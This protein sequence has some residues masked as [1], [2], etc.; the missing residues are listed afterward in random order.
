MKKLLLSLF[1]ATVAMSAMAFNYE[2]K[3]AKRLQRSVAYPSIEATVEKPV[4]LSRGEALSMYYSPA[5]DPAKILSLNN[6]AAGMTIYQAF[7]FT[8]DVATKFAGNEVTK[9]T[10][11]TPTSEARVNPVVQ[12]TLFMTYDLTGTPFYTQEFELSTQEQTYCDVTLDTP[13]KIEAGKPFYVGWY[14]VL[15][16][17]AVYSFYVDYLAHQT[18][19]GGWVGVIMPGKTE[20]DWVNITNEAGFLCLGVTLEGENFPT[21]TLDVLVS[22]AQ[23]AVEAGQKFDLVFMMQNSGAN[24]VENLDVV[25][26]VGQEDPMGGTLSFRQPLTYNNTSIAT[27]SE[28][29]A[30]TPGVA[31]PITLTIAKVNGVDNNSEASA[32]TTYIDVLAAGTGFKRNVVAEE[33]S[34]TWCGWCPRGIETMEYVR[35]NMQGKII[36]VAIHGDDPMEAITYKNVINEYAAGYPSAIINRAWSSESVSIEEFEQLYEYVSSIPAIANVEFTAAVSEDR[37]LAIDAKTSFA[38]DITGAKDKYA[39]SIGITEDNVGPYTQTNYYN[40]D[41]QTQN[42]GEVVEEL[43]GWSDMPYEVEGVMYN[44]VARQ[45]AGYRGLSG[46]VPADVKAG[47]RY[48]FHYDL[49]LSTAVKNPDNINI[50]VYLFNKDNGMIENVAYMNSAQLSAVNNVV[51]EEENNAPVEYYN[52]QGVR[53]DNPSNGIFIRRQGSKVSKVAVK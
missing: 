31:V 41:F 2:F 42:F 38:Y 50:V 7:E 17:A 32:F 47:E 37:K 53:V 44:D 30:N 25:V 16:D 33:F 24:P 14:Y 28:L 48:D 46:S 15:P 12:G 23:P 20:L 39:L 4:N 22:Q 40:S 6:Q 51:V 19:E 5:G 1:A 13:Y 9:F 26:Q 11:I 27:L 49:K 10:C 3:P 45:L 43:E 21:N 18:D 29:V 52:L 8:A 35:E 34:G 36:P